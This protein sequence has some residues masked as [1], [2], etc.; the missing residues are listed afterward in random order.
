M[1]F[2][3]FG[4][5]GPL[6]QHGFVRNSEFAVSASAA[7][8]VTLSFTPS[9]EQLKLFPHPFEL[10]VQVI[11]LRQFPSLFNALARLVNQKFINK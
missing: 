4:G 1:C 9:E 6:S 3:Q 10:T 7:D 8:S 11:A 2:P 5:F